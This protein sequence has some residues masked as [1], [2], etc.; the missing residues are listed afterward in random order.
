[1][2]HL[3]DFN[4]R[5]Q[6]EGCFFVVFFR[7][8]QAVSTAQHHANQHKCNGFNQRAVSINKQAMKGRLCLT[9]IRQCCPT[10]AYRADLKGQAHFPPEVDEEMNIWRNHH[11]LM[12]IINAS[13]FFFSPTICIIGSAAGMLCCVWKGARLFDPREMDKSKYGHFAVV[14]VKTLRFKKKKKKS[15]KATSS[16]TNQWKRCLEMGRKMLMQHRLKLNDCCKVRSRNA[17]KEDARLLEKEQAKG[18][19][20]CGFNANNV[21]WGNKDDCFLMFLCFCT[22]LSFLLTNP[23]GLRYYEPFVYLHTRRNASGMRFL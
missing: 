5:D 19:L 7:L 18:F 2:G 9:S 6:G 8:H 1:M 15:N 4:R 14:E 10:L 3:I 13:L 23:Y 11:N 17:Y 12:N 22:S 16:N 21:S 20:V